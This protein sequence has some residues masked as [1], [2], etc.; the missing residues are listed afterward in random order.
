MDL[1][2][3]DAHAD[4][5]KAT[6]LRE[7]ELEWVKD[8]LNNNKKKVLMS[9]HMLFTYNATVGKSS[10]GKNHPINLDLYKQLEDYIPDID[11]WLWAHE[12]NF[13]IYDEYQGL[14]KGRLIGHG[15]CPQH[16]VDA[17]DI[18]TANKDLDTSKYPLPGL[19]KGNWK[20]GINGDVSNCGFALMSLDGEECSV[21]YYEINMPEYGVYEPMKVT[22]QEKITTSM[23]TSKEEKK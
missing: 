10:D 12:H 23:T 4:G 9:H 8:K 22:Y 3:N 1:A 7:D 17:K 21:K 19:A 13:Y 20:L 11:L 14:K 5:S 16:D 2:F 6:T 18:Y 15:S